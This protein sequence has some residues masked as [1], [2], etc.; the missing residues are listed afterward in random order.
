ML[1]FVF[2]ELA[3]HVGFHSNFQ[4]GT[5]IIWKDLESQWKYRRLLAA[6]Y[7][8]AVWEHA[9]FNLIWSLLP[10]SGKKKEGCS[11]EAIMVME[12]GRQVKV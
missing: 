2:E 11:R 3:S 6:L 9:K 1:I 8:T 12:T 4:A 7:S 10:A 5:D